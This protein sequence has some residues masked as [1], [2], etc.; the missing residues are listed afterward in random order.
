MSAFATTSRTASWGVAIGWIPGYEIA[1]PAFK[2]HADIYYA[3]GKA[4]KSAREY[5]AY[6]SLVDELRPIE[7]LPRC[8]FSWRR[9]EANRGMVAYTND[10]P[11][12]IGSVWRD[13]SDSKMAVVAVNIS[14][15]RQTI[16]F[17]TPTGRDDL[18]AHPVDGQSAPEF[19]VSAGMA[20]LTLA[21]RQI[22]ILEQSSR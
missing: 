4:R 9:T 21:P 7:P 19:A 11:A 15:A 16:R 20:A 14:P 3:F 10:M 6:G 12:V 1:N 8:T 13:A 5:L 2:T 22:A 17:R 18:S